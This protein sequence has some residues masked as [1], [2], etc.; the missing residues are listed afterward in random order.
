[1]KEIERKKE[2]KSFSIALWR[3]LSDI[4]RKWPQFLASK[5]HVNSLLICLFKG[6]SNRCNS[7]QGLW[8]L[9]LCQ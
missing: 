3:F 9:F 8:I 7:Q 2:R 6:K 1:M 5:K 4:T